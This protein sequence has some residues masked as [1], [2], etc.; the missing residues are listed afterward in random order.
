MT[1]SVMD[2]GAIVDAGALIRAHCRKDDSGFAVYEDGWSDERVH[3][4][5]GTATISNIVGLRRRLIGNTRRISTAP[6]AAQARRIEL[7][8]GRVAELENSVLS[9]MQ[10]LQRRFQYQPPQGRPRSSPPMTDAAGAKNGG[11]P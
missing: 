7:L 11:D 9:A 3:K 10:W 2:Y 6:D 8:E 5:L 4:E 1:K